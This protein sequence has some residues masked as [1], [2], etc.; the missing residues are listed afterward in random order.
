MG[1]RHRV[2][3]RRGRSAG[4]PRAPVAE[5]TR[6]RRDGAHDERGRSRRWTMKRWSLALTTALAACGQ[7]QPA[8]APATAPPD[9]GGALP[10]AQAVRKERPKPGEPASVDY[11]TPRQITLENGMR[12]LSV[13]APGRGVSLNYVVRRGAAASPV[14]KSGLAGLVARMLTESTKRRSSMALAEAVE[15]LGTTLSSPATRDDPRVS[16]T[17]PPEAFEHALRPPA[18]AA[19]EP[20]PA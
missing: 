11:P 1:R 8:A 10:P 6:R 5:P 2:R 20:A 14:K 15:S 18:A 13:S 7:Q 3:A 4:A 16:L 17:V 19:T 9:A 12:V